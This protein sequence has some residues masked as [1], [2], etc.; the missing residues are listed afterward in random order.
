VGIDYGDPSPNT[1]GTT[2]HF[3]VVVGM[4]SDAKGNYF[5]F[6]D[7]FT[8]QNQYGA[9]SSNK[10]YYNSTT[11]A[12]TGTFLIGSRG[13]TKNYQVSMIRKSVK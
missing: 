11:G 12:I 5:Q 3:V 10:L 1:D 6:Y 2:N 4:G 9:S 8:N 13:S 7:N